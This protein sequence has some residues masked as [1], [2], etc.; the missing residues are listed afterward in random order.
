M[1]P[2]KRPSIHGRRATSL[3]LMQL[4]KQ[5]VEQDIVVLTSTIAYGDGKD[6]D[7]GFLRS[8]LDVKSKVQVQLASVSLE[9]N[10]VATGYKPSNANYKVEMLAGTG[11]DKLA[12]YS[13]GVEE[14]QYSIVK[15]LAASH[16][17]ANGQEVQGVDISLL[18]SQYERLVTILDRYQ[19]LGN[20]SSFTLV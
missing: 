12:S 6:I 19:S 3:Q 20:V 15:D 2:M 11:G 9:G 8:L 4:L 5:A 1:I 18:A 10:S 16:K 13:L 17:G 14:A 7:L